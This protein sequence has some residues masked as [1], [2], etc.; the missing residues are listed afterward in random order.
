MLQG[1][2]WSS[3]AIVLASSLSPLQSVLLLRF[4]PQDNLAS[5]PRVVLCVIKSFP[6]RRGFRRGLL[7]FFQE[8]AGVGFSIAELGHSMRLRPRLYTLHS[9][10][11]TIKSH[12]F[13]NFCDFICTIQKI[14]VT[15]AGKIKNTIFI[16]IKLT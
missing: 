13:N 12:K 6:F 14:V 7:P 16:Y 1:V 8:G 5:T 9:T 11:Y 2:V 3:P 4:R 10:L 15:L